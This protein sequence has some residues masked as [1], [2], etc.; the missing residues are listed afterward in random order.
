MNQAQ[1][2]ISNRLQGEPAKIL[3]GR[4]VE[5]KRKILCKKI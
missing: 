3:L 4:Y 2:K 1:Q 5:G